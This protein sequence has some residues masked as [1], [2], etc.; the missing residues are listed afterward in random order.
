MLPGYACHGSV[1]SEVK[2]LSNSHSLRLKKPAHYL[3]TAFVGPLQERT[4]T[5]IQEKALDFLLLVELTVL[6]Y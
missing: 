3:T 2:S 4:K 1:F 6:L 5:V